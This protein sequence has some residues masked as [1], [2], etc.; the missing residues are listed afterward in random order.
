MITDLSFHHHVKL[1]EDTFL[2]RMIARD[3]YGHFISADCNLS[4]PIGRLLSD[5][6]YINEINLREQQPHK[7]LV[8]VSQCREIKIFNLI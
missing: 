2:S 5:L 6:G 4:T 8:I 1:P 3:N 7:G